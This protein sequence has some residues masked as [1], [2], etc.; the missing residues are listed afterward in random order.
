MAAEQPPETGV[1]IYQSREAV[2]VF[3]DAD[4]LEAAVSAL[5]VAGFDRAAISV[6]GSAN[7]L[8][9]RIGRLY[10]TV[11]QIE[12]DARVPRAGFVSRGSR[13]EGAAAAVVAPFYLGGLAGAAA[14][15]ASG[16]VLAAAIAGTIL[17][18][19]AGGGLGALLAYSVARHRSA[20][21][22]EQ[23]AHGGLVLWVGVH[24]DEAAARAL[25][26]LRQCGGRDVHLHQISKAWGASDR[27]LSEAP[28]DPFLESEPPVR[29]PD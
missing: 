5:E 19:A 3:A 8:R 18:G 25:D 2:A 15:V 12:D 28:V 7:K 20:Q 16:G 9:E 22:A 21:I 4:A 26:V 14:I 23:L 11:R 17:G 27:P 6:L 10:D 1:L 13:I 29:P 24:T